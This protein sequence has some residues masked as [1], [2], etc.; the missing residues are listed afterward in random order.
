MMTTSTFI[1]SHVRVQSA[2]AFAE[3]TQDLERQL[4]TF[5]PTVLQ[6]LRPDT[7]SDDDA[8]KQIKAMAGESGFVLFD[9]VDHGRLLSIVGEK[10][11]A[12][13]YVTG[14]PLIAVQMT[15]HNL[16]AGLYAPLRMLVFED[17]EGRTRLEYDKPS[18]LFGQFDDD[19]IAAVADLLDRKL[20]D[21]VAVATG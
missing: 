8:T 3:V 21:L 11:K 5:D 9:K 13:Q 2:K 10:R 4:G 12:I 19:R 20:E 15:R 7:E 17:E 14:N 6:S 1:T 18:S 16:A